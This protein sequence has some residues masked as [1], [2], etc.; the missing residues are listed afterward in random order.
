MTSFDRLYLDDVC[1]HDGNT[2]VAL[3]DAADDV[4]VAVAAD[5]FVGPLFVVVTVVSPLLDE[6]A[7]GVHFLMSASLNLNDECA[8]KRDKSDSM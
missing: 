1:I 8:E 4:A 2:E 7:D 3:G 5:R 6:V